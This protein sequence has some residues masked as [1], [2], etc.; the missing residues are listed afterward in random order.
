M[1]FEEGFHRIGIVVMVVALV[2]GT[3][4]FV[5]GEPGG[6]I[7]I[8]VGVLFVGFSLLYAAAYVI[9]GFMKKTSEGKNED[10]AL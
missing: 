4:A 1:N 6:A 5:A 7:L 8:T 9:K 10:Q 2:L 3:L